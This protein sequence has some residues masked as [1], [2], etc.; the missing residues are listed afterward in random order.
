MTNNN[1]LMLSIMLESIQTRDNLIKKQEGEIE[2]IK[3]ELDISEWNVDTLQAK[4][5]QLERELETILGESKV[6]GK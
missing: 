5:E 3:K 1:A 4:C 6:K 2:L